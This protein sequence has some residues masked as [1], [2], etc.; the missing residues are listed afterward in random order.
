LTRR[1]V[2]QLVEIG[3]LAQ[4]GLFQISSKYRC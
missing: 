1:A 3:E 2:E 4:Q